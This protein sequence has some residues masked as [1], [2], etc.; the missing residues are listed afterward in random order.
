MITKQEPNPDK[1]IWLFPISGTQ[2]IRTSVYKPHS[3][4]ANY[5]MAALCAE[6][7]VFFGSKPTSPTLWSIKYKKSPSNQLA[8]IAQAKQRSPVYTVD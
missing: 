7:D 5:I 1:R 2:E 8:V 3:S 6:D 4:A